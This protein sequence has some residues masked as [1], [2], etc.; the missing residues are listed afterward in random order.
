MKLNIGIFVRERIKMLK[1][2]RKFSI[3]AKQHFNSHQSVY[4]QPAR[5]GIVT[6]HKARRTKHYF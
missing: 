6:V 3:F 1:V 5:A 4:Q 2:L